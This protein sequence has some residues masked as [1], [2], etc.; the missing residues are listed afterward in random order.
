MASKQQRIDRIARAA[1]AGERAARHIVD[2]ERRAKAMALAEQIKA[3][4]REL[5]KAVKKPVRGVVRRRDRG[6]EL[7]R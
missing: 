6:P 4:T 3:R 2:P 1:G 5:Q 7:E